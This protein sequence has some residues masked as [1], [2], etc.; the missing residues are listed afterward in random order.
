MQRRGR[1][2]HVSGRD[3]V[4]GLRDLARE[5]FGLMARTVLT[6]WGVKSTSDFGELVFNMIEEDIMSKQDSD[7]RADFADI[8]D[9]EEA[10]ERDMTI[11]I[12]D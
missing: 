2:G 11:E 8:F 6:Q 7:T 1:R 9:F 10:F 12:L 5:R 4:L 3:L